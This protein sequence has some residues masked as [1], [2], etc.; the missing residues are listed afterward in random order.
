METYSENKSVLSINCEAEERFI[1][2]VRKFSSPFIV[3]GFILLLTILFQGFSLLT[4]LINIGYGVVGLYLVVLSYIYLQFFIQKKQ[5]RQEF[6]TPYYKRKL[7]LDDSSLRLIREELT[8]KLMEQFTYEILGK[9][10]QSRVVAEVEQTTSRDFLE[11]KKI[12]K[13]VD[14]TEFFEEESGKVSSFES[15]KIKNTL[16]EKYSS[17]L[18]D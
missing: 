2:E 12:K 14:E 18:E 15:P 13:E 11:S 4:L 16:I 1:K 5:I 3:Y 10:T 8:P 17:F 9:N 7:D 6:L